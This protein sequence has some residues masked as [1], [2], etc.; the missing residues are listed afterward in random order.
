MVFIMML[1]DHKE[2]YNDSYYKTQILLKLHL[3][4][5]GNGTICV[6]QTMPWNP[7]NGFTMYGAI[8]C[9]YKKKITLYAL[10]I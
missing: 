3:Y 9:I 6:T 5:L 10:Y 2:R 8:N 1:I 7:I 4:I